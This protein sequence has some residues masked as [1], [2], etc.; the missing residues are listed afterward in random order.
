MN[1]PFPLSAIITGTEKPRIGKKNKTK[2]EK[3]K[4]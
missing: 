3:N 4:Q 2:N 1:D